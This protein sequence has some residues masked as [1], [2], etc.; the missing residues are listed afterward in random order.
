MWIYIQRTGDIYW[1]H[2]PVTEL[3]GKGYA[4]AGSLKND[5]ASQCVSDLGPIPRGE[6]T[7]GSIGDHGPSGQLRRSLPLT[8]SPA[9]NMCGR[10]N[11]LIHGDSA[12]N[13][14]WAS[15]GCII[16]R[17]RDLREKIGSSGDTALRVVA[18]SV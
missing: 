15:G 14:G 10:S 13:P 4:G 9:N 6:Y 18:E 16:I 2:P 12:A 1:Q 3:V 5:P 17:E 7:I 11:F 8:P